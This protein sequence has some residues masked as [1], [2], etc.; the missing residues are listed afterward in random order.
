MRNKGLIRAFA[1]LLT[2]VCAWQLTFTFKSR[3]VE[4]D[5]K[6][7][8]KGD[9]AK[10]LAYLDSMAD[11]TVYTFL[12][13]KK[14][15]YK[16]V[17]SHEMNFGLDLKGGMTVTLEVSVADLVRSLSNHS[18]DSTFNAAW[19]RA[20][21]LQRN[22]PD[23]FVTLFGR[24]FEEIDPDASLAAVFNTPG[25]K[26]K[27]DYNSTNKEVLEVLRKETDAAIGNAFKVIRTRIDRF[28]IA[29]PNIRPLQP[30][31][32]I[33][34]EL[35]GI[36]DPA[37]VRKLL[38]GT[39]TLEFWE[40]YENSEVYPVL[41]Q[42]NEKLKDVL[43]TTPSA[44]T[45]R[46]ALPAADSARSFDSSLQQPRRTETDS[47]AVA[48]KME[49]S[50][51]EYALF[52]VL[53][54][55]IRQQGQFYPGPVV[56]TARYNDT[57]TVNKYL[58]L[59]QVQSL[60]P[61][62]L[63]FKW[64]SKAIDGKE[65][66]FELI[67]I[68][69]TS[70]DG[71][72]PLT[73]DAIVDARQ[74]YGQ[75]GNSPEVSM[76]MNPEGAKIWARLTKDNIGKSIAIVLDNDV[77]SYPMVNREITGG[78][79]SITGLESVEEAKDLANILKSGKMP[80]PA[81]IIQEEI[82]GP[83][84][85]QEAVHS[86]M[87]AFV[88]AFLL[89]LGYLLFFYG[90]HAGMAASLALIAN[91][92]FLLGILASVGAV[93]TL[94]GIAGIVL[95]IG[96]AVDANVLIDEGIRN[97]LKGGKSLRIAVADGFK[98]TCPAIID[99][100]GVT[101][102]TGIVLYIFGS[103]PIKGFATT[104]IIGILTSLFTAIFI[105][106]LIV[107]WQLS[108]NR[109]INFTAGLT[110]NWI[111]NTRFPFLA[112]RK[113][114]YVL[115]I[116]VILV[117]LVSI[118]TRGLNYG[119]DLRGGRTYVV[120]FDREVKVAEIGDAL[121]AVFGEAPEVKTFGGND[122]VEIT[123]AYKIGEMADEADPE[124]ENLLFEGLQKGGFIGDHVSKEQF[125]SDYK[126]T[127]QKV[128]PTISD[129]IKKDAVIAVILSLIIIFLYMVIRFRN[130]QYGLGAILALAHD[131][132]VVIG[133]FSLFDGL[134]PFSMKIDQSFIAAIL[135]VT[136]YSIND[137]V[138]IFD[139]IRESLHRH[140]KQTIEANID[141]AMNA[142][143]R[144][145]F[146]TSL[147]ILVILLAVFLFG[148]TSIRAFTFALLVGVLAGTYSSVFIA[149]PVVYDTKRWFEKKAGS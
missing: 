11:K 125:D 89:V 147:T 81:H 10:E 44:K 37:R 128:G 5:A 2:L 35:P 69:V 74:D 100:Q 30:H 131:T 111:R 12:G 41:M 65:N 21:Q 13:L 15:T 79:S 140:P 97:E 58:S 34:V 19:R 46:A 75:M 107:E 148:G 101:L 143:L 118:F 130:W 105:N 53:S 93:L 122:Q 83:S 120:K 36:D 1:I 39:A 52:S 88:S 72:A 62:D 9:K 3:Q 14:Y 91:L 96:L 67:A 4:K 50:K 87:Y 25:L 112:K 95:A 129:D 77:R 71:K 145:T 126:L 98:N 61:R 76:T 99:A 22:S 102:L 28:G 70:R 134:L 57:A 90:K 6:E 45:D 144:R 8:A 54:P 7:Y 23:D 142:T 136:G 47:A 149:T 135:A 127:S 17:K 51:K 56:G 63:T 104:L 123:T 138:I 78:R 86:S 115:S 141:Q 18:T 38:Q 20:A 117:S 85:G 82:I 132:L 124:V 55:R 103:G 26:G 133:I 139:R 119:T 60:I 66:I 108:K 109:N 137:T 64:T 43:D 114:F 146:N 24:A 40:T 121:A 84:L 49:N 73:G 31:G 80:A 92:F 106:R 116:A 59:P 16:A 68:K 42:I 32:R 48:G 110:A 33:L 27:I 29:Y 113:L 94:P